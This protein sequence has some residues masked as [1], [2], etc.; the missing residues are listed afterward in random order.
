MI[1]VFVVLLL[2]A[3]ALAGVALAAMTDR[4]PRNR[5]VGVRT[6]ATLRDDETFAL[7]NRVASPTM[8]A[9]AVALGFGAIG[10]VLTGGVIGWA[11]FVAA[12]VVALGLNAVG[13]SLG[14]R[15]A[16]AVPEPAAEADDGCGT[17]SCAA[18][19]LRGVCEPELS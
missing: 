14:T 13:G 12:M 9:G 6:D 17:G 16:A 1:A 4:L 8:L 19:S 10:G 18:C 2:A 3:L 11:L 7:G 15:A 5:W